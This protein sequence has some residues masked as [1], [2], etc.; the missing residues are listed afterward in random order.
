MKLVDTAGINGSQIL[1]SYDT[2]NTHF[3]ICADACK[4]PMT[5]RAKVTMEEQPEAVVAVAVQIKHAK[6]EEAG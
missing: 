4:I 2:P 3:S 5:L 6:L 1:V